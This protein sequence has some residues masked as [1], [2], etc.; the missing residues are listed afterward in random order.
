MKQK[1]PLSVPQEHQLGK[2]S[3]TQESSSERWEERNPSLRTFLGT[4][5]REVSNYLALP[6]GGKKHNSLN[7]VSSMKIKV[8]Y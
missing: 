8:M 1:G 3:R 6:F 4:L 2:E 7:W 5:N